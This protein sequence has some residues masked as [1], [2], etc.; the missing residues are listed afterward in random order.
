[1]A[2]R[3]RKYTWYLKPKIKAINDTIAAEFAA[4]GEIDSS[5]RRIMCADGRRHNLWG[6][7]VAV[8]TAINLS[9]RI[10]RDFEV[11]RQEGNG[12]IVNVSFLFKKKRRYP[13][14]GSHTIPIFT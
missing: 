1:M 8:I 3:E 11:F 12:K 14:N 13:K 7:S 2:E 4:N 5:T 10:G 6:C 9:N